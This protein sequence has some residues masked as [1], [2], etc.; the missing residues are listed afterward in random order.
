MSASLATQRYRKTPKGVLTNMYH[1]QVE[2]SKK[3]GKPLS[4][5]SLDEFHQI[6]LHNP[7]F[8]GLY[9]QW[10]N[11]GCQ[12]YDKPSID[13]KNPDGWY[14]KDNI[15]VMSWRENRV[16]G[17]KE[18]SERRTTAVVMR[19]LQGDTLREF[20]SVKNA[21]EATGICLGLI[22]ACCQGKRNHTRGLRF[23]Y[24]GDK[25]RKKNPELLA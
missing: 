18:N 9:E 5:Y 17:D 2:R 3:R 7:V 20:E 24:R 19:D 21:V 4:G 11:N 1:K 14:T 16:K 25:F 12:Y 8:L 6:F 15:Q 23:S 13:R 22:V 10:I